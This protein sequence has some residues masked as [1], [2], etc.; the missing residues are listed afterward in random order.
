MFLSIV[1]LLLFSTVYFYYQDT[2]DEYDFVERLTWRQSQQSTRTPASRPRYDTS[3]G[4]VSVNETD[5]DQVISELRTSM[6]STLRKLKKLELEERKKLGQYEAEVRTRAQQV[7]QSLRNEEERH[8]AVS[9]RFRELHERVGQVSER[10]VQL[11][12]R[13]E[14]VNVPRVRV[15]ETAALMKHLSGFLAARGETA[16]PT[17]PTR[18]ARSNRKFSVL[19]SK[20]PDDTVPTPT[21]SF[22]V[23]ACGNDPQKVINAYDTT[24]LSCTIVTQYLTHFLKAV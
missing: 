23:A 19:E 21:D 1:I 11:S 15:D 8:D 9:G 4:P 2:F 5:E 3:S 12:D 16:Q 18:S 17:A 7:L 24:I 20:A 13:L 14:A 22:S 6:L 10:A